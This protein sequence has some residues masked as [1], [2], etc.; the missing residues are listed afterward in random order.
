VLVAVQSDGVRE[1][2]VAMLGA[3]P[4]FSVVAE[5]AN[6][7]Q[8]LDLARRLRPHLALIEVQLSG[9]CGW[10]LIQA[11]QREGLARVLVALGVRADD[12]AATQA[13]AHAYVQV[14][15]APRELLQAVEA[16]LAAAGSAAKTEANLLPD[17][18]AVL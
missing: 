18:H 14:P 2:L 9:C 13:G 6:D 12:Y 10:W 8:A 1:A 15:A 4:G 17:T 5:A 3:L 16:A 7:E 11:I